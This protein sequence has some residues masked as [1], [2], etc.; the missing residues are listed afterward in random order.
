[1]KFDFLDSYFTIKT[2]VKHFA[3]LLTSYHW[4]GRFQIALKVV[5]KITYY[6][7]NQVTSLSLYVLRILK[8]STIKLTLPGHTSQAMRSGGIP[9]NILWVTYPFKS[10]YTRAF[11]RILVAVISMAWGNNTYTIPLLWLSPTVRKYRTS[12]GRSWKNRFLSR[13]SSKYSF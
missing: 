3:K 12:S 4:S 1:M 10:E 8:C 9:W 13:F 6:I 7:R 5:S 2:V 11:R